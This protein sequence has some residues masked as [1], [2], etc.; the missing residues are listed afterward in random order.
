MHI[1]IERKNYP[2]SG[3]EHSSPLLRTGALTPELSR[4]STDFVK[5]S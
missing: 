5:W 1:K 2:E 3:L 4:T